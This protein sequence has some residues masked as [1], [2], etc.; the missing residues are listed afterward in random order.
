[1]GALASVVTAGVAEVPTQ[2]VETGRIA[3]AAERISA[4]IDEFSLLVGQLVDVLP[5]V[6]EDADEVTTGVGDLFDTP[7]V[8]AA[9]V[10]VRTLPEASPVIDGVSTTEMSAARDLTEEA[11]NVP[12][13]RLSRAQ[14]E[15]KFEKHAEAF[16]IETPRGRQGFQEFEQAVREFVDDPR[17]T[18]ISGSYRGESAIVVLN[19][20]SR[21]MVLL[22]PDGSFWSCWLL[23]VQQLDRLMTTGGFGLD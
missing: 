15:K 4:L 18:K 13:L 7:L 6:A 9:T 1:V 3:A 16:G 21:L 2:S 20:R 22:H 14:V 10:D 11:E 8:D 5:L 19:E 12:E 17:N 23:D